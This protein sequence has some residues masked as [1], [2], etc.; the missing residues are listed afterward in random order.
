MQN[1]FS[2]GSV[3]KHILRQAVP[4][5][6]AQLI[7]LLYNVVDRIYL[8][9]LQGTG[10]AAL[11]GVGIVFP[12]ITIISAFTNL[13]AS[14]GAPLFSIARG[15]GRE[16]EASRIMNN[17]FSLL[18]LT[19]LAIL[20][21]GYVC[22]RPI[23]HL[24]GAS[25]ATY[26][27]A[28]SYLSIYLTGTIFV[29]IGTGMNSFINAQGFPRMGMLVVMTG[30]VMNLVLDPFFIFA[31]HMGVRGAAIATVLSQ[32]LT[33]VLVLCFFL[34]KKT[35][36]R[37]CPSDMKLR[38]RLAGRIAGL[39]MSGFIMAV[40][41]SLVQIVC[42]RTLKIYGGDLY[43]GIMTVL[44]SVREIANVVVVGITNGAQPVIGFNYGAG[45][46]PRVKR[47]IAITSGLAIGYTTVFWAAI[48]LFPKAFIRLYSDSNALLAP[49]SE[50]MQLYFFGFFFMA[51]QFA[52]QSTFVALGKAKHSIFFSLFRKVVIVVPL[53]LILPNMWGLGVDG[54][55][56]AEPVS[57]AVGGLAS[58]LTML[59][60]VG[61]EMNGSTRQ[62]HPSS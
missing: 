50:A 48:M 1:D 52:G 8:G 59:F 6:I 4:L 30:A 10:G 28:D 34:G 62:S 46:W 14:G 36:F 56:L 45:A 12:V 33:A 27:Y 42:N 19:A 51:F 5:T 16:R 40:T 29:M 17:T 22:K 21:V 13:F 47:A 7:Q 37:L 31:L 55:F 23:L 44:N 2:K 3:A 32:L 60:V 38:P 9:H 11:T 53:T 43:I 24:F 15:E 57:N 20:I 25:E 39:G 49:G 54:V 41:N 61:R 35:L 58:F 26:P 18:C